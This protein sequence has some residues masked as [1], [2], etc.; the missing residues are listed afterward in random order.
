MRTGAIFARGSCRAL[1]WVVV[2]LGMLSLLGSAQATAQ[3]VESATYAAGVVTVTMSSAVRVS[4]GTA[5]DLPNSVFTIAGNTAVDFATTPHTVSVNVGGDASFT[6]PFTTDLTGISTQMT[7]TA[8]MGEEDARIV[9]AV[10]GGAV[11]S[12]TVTVLPAAPFLP[13]IPIHEVQRGVAA[14][15]T[16]PEAVGGTGTLTYSI[17]TTLPAGLTFAAATRK[18][19][20]TTTAAAGRTTQ[21]YSVTDGGTPTTQDFF[22][23]VVEPP[24]LSVTV[25]ADPTT[26]AEGGM[27]TITA[28]ANRPVTTA[29]GTV[30]VNLAVVGEATL[31]ANSITI[32][33]GAESGSVTLTAAEDDDYEPETVT[34]TVTGTGVAANHPNVMINVTDMAPPEILSVVVSAD[35][36]TIAEGGTSTIT[37]MANRAVMAS[38]GTV[39][40]NL[41]VV[42]EA[43]LS[44]NSITIAAGAQSG[45]V[46]LTSTADDDY[47][48]D[49]VTV[50]AAGSGVAANHPNVVINVTDMAPP[51]ALT[52]TVSAAPMT[53][54]EGGTSTI[55]AMAS[56]MVAAGDGTVTV[57]LSV[58]GD[59]TLSANSIT[60]AV[61]AQSGTVMLTSTQ[62]D[63]YMNDTVTVTASGAGITGNQ[64]VE[65]TVTD[66]DMAPSTTL[67]H[68]TEIS[69]DRSDPKTVG[70]T[71]RQHVTE[72]VLTKAT[73][74]VRWSHA[75]LRDLWQ[76]VA[77]GSKPPDVPVMLAMMPVPSTES[78]LSEAENEAGH[79]DVTIGTS[80]MVVVPKKPKSNTSVGY[81]EGTG[82]TSI[83]FGQDPDAENEAFKL[84]VTDASGFAAGSMLESD[85]HVIEDDDPQN[86]MLKRDGSG[87]IYEGRSDVKFDV[88][89]DPPREDLVLE[90][91]F[92]L[93]DVDG[94]TVA[95]GDNY[96]DKSI[97]TIPT[98]RDGKDTVTLTLDDNDENRI[99]DQIAL[100]A[101]VVVYALDTG[102]YR[103]IDDPDPVEI[104]VY[105]VH[106]LPWLNVAGAMS[107]M[108]GDEAG[109]DLTLTINR[110]PEN[111]HAVDPETLEYTSE[112]LS[113]AVN[114]SG[115]DSSD[116]TLSMN[117]VMVDEYKHTA[118]KDWMQKV[119]VNV[120]ADDDGDIGEKMLALEFVV[121]PAAT[122][123]GP[124]PSAGDAEPD[125][126]KNSMAATTLTIQDATERLV[127]ARTQDEIDA[128]VSAAMTKAAGTDGL[129]PGEMVEILGSELFSAAPGI[130]VDYAA[131]SSDT[132][133]AA[134]SGSDRRMITVTPKAEG[135]TMVTV[136]ATAT[137]PSGAAIVDQTKPNVAQIMFS[138]DVVLQDLTFMVALAEGADMNL[139]EGGMG[140]MVTVTTN[141]PVTENTEVMLMRDGSSSASEDDYTLEPPLVTIM[142]GH[143][144]G[145]TMVMATEDGMPEDMEMLT[146]FLVVD[147]M[148][149]TDKSVSFY[150][151]DAAVPAL[152]VIAQLLLAALMAV[153]GYR[154]YRR[155]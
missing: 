116:F 148:Q 30:T 78:W 49:T 27:S 86:I 112:A 154:R 90:V 84:Y 63:D 76:G 17:T 23:D 2:V 11:S 147:G 10:T 95:S 104:T 56:R 88:T 13:R 141:R 37:A 128:A 73:V 155:R 94:Q 77:A 20:G 1:K 25:S 107:V 80:A 43:T 4:S 33:A 6:V 87:V 53:I 105:D 127:W 123:Y 143:K 108:E 55:T 124:R 115:V 129:N 99:D 19:T 8:P 40:V 138:V 22:L 18:I 79:D 26:I 61:G 74:K 24:A 145:T 151:W 93:K 59:A 58:V 135:M 28:M 46:T 14:D 130:V 89:A 100:H 64:E 75:Q 39:T 5:A 113:I 136:T 103:G 132:A 62:D 9:N 15:I 57:N 3:T 70:G 35:P 54:A 83:H 69:V 110:N 7:Y 65:I 91:R 111:T 144:M 67:G 68:I 60:I 117:P 29:D 121:N 38:D 140:G 21:T 92:D 31:S 139:A 66:D 44:A 114:P 118:A 126:H 146:L 134:G 51:S 41:R 81:E 85:V 125:D 119:K 149:M 32:A 122:T 50:T 82:S 52:V 131:A 96:I 120:K 36:T 34:V 106:K 42:G 71:K 98:G 16:L 12:F 48:P 109:V 97:G 137:S 47:E 152:P 142:A 153:G 45:S 72:G 102:A 101:E 133:I 150:L